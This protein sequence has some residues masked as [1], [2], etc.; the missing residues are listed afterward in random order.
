MRY[1]VQLRS[2]KDIYYLQDECR[3]QRFPLPARY[4]RLVGQGGQQN[5]SGT[6]RSAVL[7]LCVDQL[8]YSGP[9]K[10]NVYWLV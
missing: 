5:N 8:G 7:K 10:I 3:T 2:S 4:L 9:F 1:I 6:R